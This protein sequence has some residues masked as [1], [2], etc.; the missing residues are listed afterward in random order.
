MEDKRSLIL[1][2]VVFIEH[3]KLLVLVDFFLSSHNKNKK[4]KGKNGNKNKK[5][6][7][8]GEQ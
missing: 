2:R 5:V 7:G 3:L 8:G 1:E 6:F 4:D